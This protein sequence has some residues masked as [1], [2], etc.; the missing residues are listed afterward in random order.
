MLDTQSTSV[1]NPKGQKAPPAGA[2]SPKTREIL[3][4]LERVQ[5]AGYGPEQVFEDWLGMIVATLEVL[6][7]QFMA[8]LEG[9]AWTA[10]E[11]NEALFGRL[12]E[13]YR[14]DYG[15]NPRF[16]LD[17]FVQAFSLLLDSVEDG[18]H[19]TLG[20][21]YMN[22]MGGRVA[23]QFFTPMEI[24]GLMAELAI[25][26]AE[27]L[28]HDRLLEAIHK[29]P[30]AAAMLL[31]GMIVPEEQQL[32][33]MMARVIPQAL[34]YYDPVTVHDPCCGSGVMFLAAAGKLPGWMVQLGLVRFYGQDVS[35]ICVQMAR[36]NIMLYGLNGF[37]AAQIVYDAEYRLA[38]ALQVVVNGGEIPQHR[39][40]KEAAGWVHQ[41]VT[42][43]SLFPAVTVQGD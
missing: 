28:V 35:Q 29:S 42:Q 30:A 8:S 13:R 2:G 16:Y 31:A 21:L 18:Y 12:R 24:A 33:W 3:R 23:G 6:P 40:G 9:R 19:D 41:H 17:M 32:N 38:G 43:L 25:D 10:S 11:E 34:E 36:A 5:R 4:I 37:H 27:E 22:V 39:D 15:D 20:E 14:A 7:G 1:A 26:G